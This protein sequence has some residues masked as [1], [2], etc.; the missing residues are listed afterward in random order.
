MKHLV[1]LVLSTCM[2]AAPALASLQVKVLKT[3]GV[4]RVAAAASDVYAQAAEGQALNE[5]MT[6]VT[7]DNGRVTLEVGPN[8]TVR[9]RGNAKMVIGE[10]RPQMTKFKLVSGKI[11][12][13]FKGLTGGEKFQLE[14][15]SNSAVASVK[16]T[17]FEGAIENGTVTLKTIYGDIVI[18]V[19]GTMFDV[20]QGSEF[21]H[22]AEGAMVLRSI[23]NADLDAWLALEEGAAAGDASALH[24]FVE[25]ARNDSGHDNE[26][27]TQIREDDFAVGRS[28]KDVHGNLARVD[29]RLLRP[30]PQTIQFVNLVKR[31]SYTYR[32]KFAYGGSSG[33]RF[34][35][36]EGQVTFNRALPD[37]VL[38]W[39]EFFSANS[40]SIDAV[41]AEI[42]LAN[43]RFSDPESTRDVIRRETFFPPDNAPREPDGFVFNGS[44][45][46]T[47]GRGT[48]ADGSATG[49]LWATSVQAAY[50]DLNGN[51]QID[52]DAAQPDGARGE[53]NTSNQ[54][55]LQFEG[56]ALNED[57]KVLNL[58]D[59][60]KSSINDPF[61]LAKTLSMEGILS[62]RNS[63]GSDFMRKGNIDLVVI[64]DMVIAIASKYGPSVASSVGGGSD[65]GN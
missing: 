41:H 49:D 2:A 34:D 21:V 9:L 7:G 18:D 60:T 1:A 43:G 55:N 23:P 56:Y 22:P 31:D 53:Y 13:F 25:D 61:G 20:A 64:P 3:S 28:L 26:V 12:G 45:F 14:F 63:D 38:D 52:G 44:R 65:S 54:I 42:T 17:T 32:G 30:D 8:N 24:N 58:G 40:D 51:G 35:Y 48:T 57:G 4:V 15:E 33:P 59:F 36:L 5:G 10:A 37:N 47:A 50:R 46:I 11:R 6:L 19:K 39:P 62:A 29:Q 27:I 16:G